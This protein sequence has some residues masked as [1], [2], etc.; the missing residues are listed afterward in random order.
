MD[1][2]NITPVGH[3]IITKRDMEKIVGI[4]FFSSSGYE[5]IQARIKKQYKEAFFTKTDLTEISVSLL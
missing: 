5:G 1:E 2:E 3:E 4:E